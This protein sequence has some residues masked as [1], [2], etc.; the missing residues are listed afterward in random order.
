M[1][2]L[3][4]RIEF[5]FSN[6]GNTYE[7]STYRYDVLIDG[8]LVF[9]GNVFIESTS[10]GPIIDV[11]DIVR[12][13]FEV[14]KPSFPSTPT[15]VG[16]I[17]EV[18]VTLYNKDKSDEETITDKIVFIY[19]QQNYNSFV[20]TELYDTDIPTV[21][22]IT[23]LQG[24]S[25]DNVSFLPTYPKIP[26][27]VL[28]FDYVFGN[29][30]LQSKPSVSTSYNNGNNLYK[31][32]ETDSY[33]LANSVYE[34]SIP[35][36]EILKS[37]TLEE[38]VVLIDTSRYILSS[39]TSGFTYV[40]SGDEEGNTRLYNG[41]LESTIDTITVNTQFNDIYG[42]EI[43]DI[44]VETS[45]GTIDIDEYSSSYTTRKPTRIIYHLKKNNVSLGYLKINF[46]NTS[47]TTPFIVGISFRQSTF[48]NSFLL[49]FA[50]GT[51]KEVVF[52]P[53]QAQQIVIN[54]NWASGGNAYPIAKLDGNSRYFLKW[55]D[56]YG[57]PQIQPF[58]GTYNY[59][60]NISRSTVTNYKN[61]KKL[62]DVT[63]QGSWL[64]NT[65]YIPE[66]LYPFY[67]SIFVSPWLQLYD[68]KEDKLYDV[69]LVNTEYDEKTFNNQSRNLF[70][71]QL[72]VE[73]D[74]T[75]KIIY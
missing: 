7:D 51:K 2:F 15:K 29:G 13:Y 70:N 1:K 52:T 63:V 40:S 18:T 3:D 22:P 69:I 35:L 36:S 43:N 5:D 9:V 42:N 68:A 8:E 73:L 30:T 16:I 67:E 61:T 20:T 14:L 56:R 55:R 34:F 60:E 39:E 62:A 46:T 6:L 64:L 53:C 45:D 31:I 66:K 41:T 33:L 50:I 72:E 32:Y 10:T 71:L 58:K 75:Q 54:H 17:K 26:S 19:R 24:Y 28:T 49:A 48:D 23:F 25:Q 38:E 57:M 11:T 37:Q 21:T 47:E 27:S 65:D 12:N 4:E 44:P 74:T 59:R